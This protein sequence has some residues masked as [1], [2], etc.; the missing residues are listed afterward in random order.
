MTTVNSSIQLKAD[1]AEI[2]RALAVLFQPGDV[3]EMRA[4][5]VEGKTQAGYYSDFEILAR[6]ATGLS[7]RAAGVYV[8]LNQINPD[9]LARS[10]NRI[11]VSPEHLTVDGDVIKRRWLPIDID[12]KRLSGIS[13]TDAEH[14]A[15]INTAREIKA[16][17][18]GRGFPADSILVG[19]S[20][21]G[22][23]VLIKIDLP[24]DTES[25]SFIKAGLKVLAGKFDSDKVSIDQSVSNAARIWKQYGTLARKG[26]N[27]TARP[28][29]LARLIDVPASVVV[30]PLE[31]VQALAAMAAP[32]A[33]KQTAR[34]YQGNGQAFD[35]ESWLSR[36]NVEVT[37]SE[38]Y[39]GGTRY[40]LKA[41]PFNPSHSG[42]SAAII[43]MASG[44]LVYKC[45]HNECSDRTWADVRELLEPGYRER[46]NG[47]IENGTYHFTDL[48]NAERLIARHGKNLTYC[49]S[50]KMWLFW[51]DKYWEWVDN[52]RLIALAAETIRDIY[53]QAAD[54]PDKDKRQALLDH[55]R[56]SE[57]GSRLVA[58]VTLAQSIPGVSIQ[59]EQLDTNNLL[60]N[61]DNG[62]IDLRTGAL[63]THSQADYI[64]AFIPV[65][66]EPAATSELWDMFL[67]TIFRNSQNVRVYVQKA[68]GYS[69]TGSQNEQVV[70][71]PYGPGGNGKSTFLGAIRDCIGSDYATEIEP[72][73]FMVKKYESS[74]P[75]EGVARL[76]RKRL[77]I[78]TEIEDGQKLS[79]SLIKRMSGGEK[80][81]HEKKYESQFEYTPTHK[82][83]LT[84]NHKVTI[85]DTTLS[86]W[87][88]VKFI[89]F[90]ETIP[91]EKRIKDLREQLKAPVHQRAILAWIVAGAIAW[92]AQ[93]LGEPPE[94]TEAT[95]KYRE[96]MDLLADF[97]KE[98]C[99]KKSSEFVA[100]SELYKAYMAWCESNDI[101]PLGKNN[102]NQKLTEKGFTKDSGT[103]N[104]TIW[105]G[106]GL[107]TEADKLTIQPQLV[108]L[109]NKILES[110]SHEE[111]YE[112]VLENRGQKLTNLTTFY[113]AA[114]EGL[115][116]DLLALWVSKGRPVVF[117]GAGEN[118]ED[119]E[120]LLAFKLNERQTAA[121][122][123][124]YEK[125]KP[126]VI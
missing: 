71:F 109:V 105:R 120:Q 22:A 50:R 57:H 21:N 9:L 83:W 5:K 36:N 121:L 80:L 8:V 66:Y 37:S 110:S 124:W 69:I 94:I 90:S 95:N 13:S 1:I 126:G 97:L 67:D 73:V 118:C 47:Y 55:A 72:Q 44:A 34:P 100:V 25:L 33:P 51:N 107:L 78:S 115:P 89:N 119:L 85:T 111:N 117:L 58:M 39:N 75:N 53:R 81:S 62:T 91:E 15:A 16:F 40:I 114:P 84:G 102:F 38:P 41:C 98:C 4:L 96:E 29:R 82:L 19:D 17:L 87:R 54:E 104:K 70:F 113:E 26:D 49:Y 3:V 48:G 56:R 43:Q 20:G 14:E 2:K 11:T 92:A 35:L 46:S 88:R 93:G 68:T 101:K 122:L 63:N 112:K 10:E 42:S 24:N 106:I 32:A 23:H 12:A 6:A 27:T 79:V 74:G 65:N 31:A 61:C 30:A 64:T 60:L 86:I 52:G 103:G 28:H 77:V 45:Q 116:S 123:T 18:I 7:G 108:N 76:Y 99:R 59:I 125:N